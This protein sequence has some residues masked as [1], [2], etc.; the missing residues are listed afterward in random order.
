MLRGRA[1]GAGAQ[2]MDLLVVEEI[3]AFDCVIDAV[4]WR[5]IGRIE[6]LGGILGCGWFGICRDAS[7]CNEKSNVEGSTQSAYYSTYST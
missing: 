3:G 7:L 5:A 4:I 2:D 6:N 1:V